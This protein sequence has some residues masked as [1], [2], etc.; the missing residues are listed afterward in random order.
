[1]SKTTLGARYSCSMQKTVSKICKYPKND[2]FLKSGKIGHFPK[3]TG[4]AK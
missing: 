3:A 4:L 1:M 2:M